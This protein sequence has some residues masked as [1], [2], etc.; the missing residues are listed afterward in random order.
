MATRIEFTKQL[1]DMEDL[2]TRFGE[3][4]SSDVRAAGL[5]ATGDKGAE[6]GILEG[7]KAAERLRNNIESNCLDTMLLQQPLVGA[8]LRF[9]SATF[10]LVSDL[11]QI[12]SMTR[13]VAFIVSELSKKA[14]SRLSDS[15]MAMSARAAAMVDSAVEAFVASDVDKANEVI[16]SDNDIDRMYSE[17]QDIVVELIKA[18]KPSPKSLPE[19]LMIAKYFERVG[20]HA[21]RIA[22]WA[23]FRATG[24]RILTTGDHSA[25]DVV[26]AE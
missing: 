18:G 19:L 11:A 17:A 21:Q 4:C 22:D 3:K 26:D 23:V 8:D 1:K 5:A 25:D 16:A 9:V 13:D 15:F 2:V 10:R 20:D 7:R 12:D 24:E 14:S 6:Q